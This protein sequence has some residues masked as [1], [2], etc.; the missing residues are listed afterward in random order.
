MTESPPLPDIAPSTP[1]AAILQR[2][3]GAQRALFA[4]YHIG[5]CSSCGFRPDETLGE[6]CARNDDLSVAEVIDHIQ[7]SHEKDATLMVSPRHLKSMRDESPDL[8]LIDLRTREEHEAVKIPGSILLSQDLIQEAFAS[9]DKS[10]PVILYDHTGQRALDATAYFVGHGFSEARCLE[11]GI[12]S[13]SQQVDPSLP[14]YRIELE[15]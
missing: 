6:V 13:Y 12:D 11:G 4:R 7:Q 5:G 3:P 15:D 14:R 9:W 2:Y 10:Q 1:M 8:R